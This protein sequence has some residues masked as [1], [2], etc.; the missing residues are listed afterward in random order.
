MSL[1]SQTIAQAALADHEVN[2]FY[3]IDGLNGLSG[4]GV[5]LAPEFTS[6]RALRMEDLVAG[7]GRSVP[8]DQKP[9]LRGRYAKHEVWSRISWEDGHTDFH[10]H[11]H[12]VISG[13]RQN[14]LA[15]YKPE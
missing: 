9:A 10:Q 7:E 11:V 1:L 13:S 12:D 6:H 3:E 8:D 4:P 5:P 15:L 2:M 14:L